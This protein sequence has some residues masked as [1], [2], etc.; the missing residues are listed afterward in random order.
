VADTV[1]LALSVADT[2]AVDELL[3]DTDTV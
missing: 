2:V 1:P 3:P